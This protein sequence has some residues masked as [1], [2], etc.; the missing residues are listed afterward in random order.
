VPYKDKS[1]DKIKRKNKRKLDMI[2]R[3]ERYGTKTADK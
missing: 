1:E 3:K 2:D